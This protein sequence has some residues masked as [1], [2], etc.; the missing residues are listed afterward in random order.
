GL[1]AAGT[2]ASTA[3]YAALVRGKQTLVKP[4]LTLPDCQPSN[5]PN[6]VIQV[7]GG[8]LTIGTPTAT[9]ATIPLPST[10][11]AES[12]PSAPVAACC[13]AS[14]AS[15]G[16]PLWTIPGSTMAPAAIQGN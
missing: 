5:Y 13:A 10:T 12:V 9:I 4:F 3:T 16:D 15:S 8:S 11:P 2:S 14:N 6:A 1:P 7:T